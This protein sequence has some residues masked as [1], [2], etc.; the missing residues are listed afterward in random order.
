VSL[1]LGFPVGIAS[2][3]V[4][5]QLQQPIGRAELTA[6]RVELLSVRNH[7]KYQARA[8]LTVREIVTVLRYLLSLRVREV[9]HILISAPSLF[10]HAGFDPP[11]RRLAMV[12][13]VRLRSSISLCRSFRSPV[14]VDLRRGPRELGRRIVAG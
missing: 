1:A 12:L 3:A 4:G 13:T 9:G 7:R 2:P 14:P 8:T 10:R 11:I 5:T 6:K